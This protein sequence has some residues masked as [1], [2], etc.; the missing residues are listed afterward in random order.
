MIIQSF[1]NSYKKELFLGV[2]LP[3]HNYKIALFI[4]N[5]NLNKTTTS[6]LNIVGEVSSPNYD[7]GGLLLTG[8]EVVEDNDSAI[9]TFNSPIRW[10]SVTFVVGGALIYNDSLQN[11]NSLATFL[12]DQVYAL[13]AQDFILNLPP[14]TSNTGIIKIT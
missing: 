9:L 1:C 4:S 11:K 5:S 12:F 7:K 10:N 6:Y 2:H 14:A 3:V 13:N 8:Y